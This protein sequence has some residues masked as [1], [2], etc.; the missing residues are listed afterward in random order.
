MYNKIRHV[1]FEV[2]TEVT[3]KN[4]DFW[5]VEQTSSSET[6]VY[7]EPHP[8][9]LHS[10]KFDIYSVSHN[11]LSH[12]LHGAWALLETPPVAYLT[13][14]LNMLC[15]PN[16]HYRIHKSSPLVPVLSNIDPFH[17]T[18]SHLSKSIL[19]LSTHPRLGFLSCYFPSNFPSNNA[20]DSSFPSLVLQSLS[21][22]S[23]FNWPL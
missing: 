10:S 8:R 18:P 9:R 19:I 13:I 4:G 1:A 20:Y 17:T 2:F 14:L 16:V 23:S 6:S 11:C 12:W 5:Y 7:Y 3:M 21:I 15:N 22:S